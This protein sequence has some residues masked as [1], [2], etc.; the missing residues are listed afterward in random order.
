MCIIDYFIAP[1]S[2]DLFLCTLFNYGVICKYSV[3]VAAIDASVY[4]SLIDV[5]AWIAN[6]VIY[7]GVVWIVNVPVIV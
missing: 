5:V 6:I 4:V 3:N 2:D 1:N 7:H